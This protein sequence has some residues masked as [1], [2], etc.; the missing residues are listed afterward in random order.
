M[1]L[2]FWTVEC[3]QKRQMLP[4]EILSKI[5]CSNLYTHLFFA[6]CWHTLY[7]TVNDILGYDASST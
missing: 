6:R 7:P 1:W 3:A 2:I 4:T 5:P